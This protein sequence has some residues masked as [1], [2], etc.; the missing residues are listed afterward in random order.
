MGITFEWLQGANNDVMGKIYVITFTLLCAFNLQKLSAQSIYKL[1]DKAETLFY[2]EDFEG[3]LDYYRQI[4]ELNPSHSLALYKSEICSLLTCCREKS[5]DLLLAQ[6]ESWGKSDKFYYYWLG[7]VYLKKY[8]FDHSISAFNKFLKIEAYKSKE[9]KDESKGYIQFAEHAKVF[10]DERD[11]FEIHPMGHQINTE[12]DELSPV[13]FAKSDELLF[14]SDRSGEN[15]SKNQKFSVF[16][17]VKVNGEWSEPTPVPGLGRFPRNLSNIEVVNKDKKLY[18]YGNPKGEDLFESHPDGH[19]HWTKPDE[20]DPKISHIHLKSNFYISADESHVIFTSAKHIKDKGLDLYESYR[21]PETG[22]WSKPSPLPGFVNTEKNEDSP[23]ITKDGTT[24]FFSSDGHNSIGKY[25]IFKSTYNS[26]KKLW[27]KPIN[28]GYPINT[29]DDEMSYK[30][31]DDGISG[32]FSSDRYG[33]KGAHDIFFFWLTSD[34]TVKGTVVDS[35]GTPLPNVMVKFIPEGHLNE[36]FIM[37]T[38][39]KGKYEITTISDEFIDVEILKDSE[40]IHYDTFQIEPTAGR[41]KDIK[42]DFTVQLDQKAI[43]KNVNPIDETERLTIADEIVPID[44]LGNKF[45]LGNKSLTRNIYF[46][47]ASATLKTESNQKLNQLLKVLVD[48]PELSIEIQGHTDNQ[49]SD[50]INLKLSNERAVS[51]AQWLITNG[52]SNDRL[53]TKGFGE[54]KPLA[55]NDDEEMGR[56]LNRRIEILVIE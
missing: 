29:P 32:Y 13:Y 19:A 18:V 14:T 53:Q 5:L 4:L 16:H 12:F 8:D 55:S 21:N 27:G 26:K 31:N 41:H 15:E 6:Q 9:I 11:E 42:I 43:A 46:D 20:F 33:T 45:R 48:N 38:D 3:A 54:S 37:L 39:E 52:I 44:F 28:M 34:V 22:K 10:F 17:S 49:G 35:N 23:Y 1:E 25:D 50:D 47:Y 30:V 40:V 7:R 36:E 24:L 51:V 2:N 56:E